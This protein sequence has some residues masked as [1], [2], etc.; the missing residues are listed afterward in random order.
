M[1]YTIAALFAAILIG[2]CSNNTE[3]LTGQG[4]IKMNLV[5][6]PGG[7]DEVN[8]V[9]TRWDVQQAGADSGS[10][11]MTVWSDSATYESPETHER[12]ECSS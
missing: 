2:G 10:G 1:K 12:C 8:I 4:D 11:W 7:Y 5:D 9:V 6:S 3:P